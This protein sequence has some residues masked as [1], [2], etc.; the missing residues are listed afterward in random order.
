MYMTTS[1]L[2]YMSTPNDS[3]HGFHPA[4]GPCDDCQRTC[5]LHAGQ[6]WADFNSAQV[7]T[8]RNM[9]AMY[10]AKRKLFGRDRVRSVLRHVYLEL[11]LVQVH[12]FPMT[13]PACFWGLHLLVAVAGDESFG[14]G[15]KQ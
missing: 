10:G 4:C 8:R 15:M 3:C 1:V 7:L 13:N 2:V 12:C 14:V 9:L 5:D 11:F 6:S